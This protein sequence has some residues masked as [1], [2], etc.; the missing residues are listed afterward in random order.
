VRTTLLRHSADN[1]TQAAMWNACLLVTL[2]DLAHKRF[3]LVNL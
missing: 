3:D 1:A 2:S